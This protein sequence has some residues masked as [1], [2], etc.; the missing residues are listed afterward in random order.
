MDR[1]LGMGNALVDVLVRMQNDSLLDRMEL[2]KGSMQLIDEAKF[3]QIQ[4]CFKEMKTHKTTGGSA[5]NTM[6]GLATMGVPTGFIGKVGNDEYGT[7][8]R[9]HFSKNKIEDKMLVNP[10]LPSGIAS[11]FISPDGERT[12]GT[13]LG[14]AATL[15][16]EDLSLEMFK[17]YTYFYIEGYLVQD[18]DLILRAIELAKEAGLQVCLDMASYN[19]V[20]EE[21]DFFSLLINK[22]VDILFANEEEAKAF[23]GKEPEEALEIFAKMCSIAI[24][25]IGAE[26]SLIRKGS[27]TIR[28]S[29]I[30]IKKV[31]DTTSAGDYFSAGFLYGLTAGY[32]LERCAKIGSILSGNVIQVVGTHMAK[33]R[34]NEIKLN[35][36]SMLAE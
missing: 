21:L 10:L 25:K 30:P 27:E 3:K 12:F 14:A 15:R 5:G 32:S 22:Y 31:L 35:I 20:I 33:P 11:A 1:I 6:L 4:E 8:F 17:G 23:T 7:F 18:H 24:V 29:A 34:W 9:K 2:P 16:A 28:V 36:D 26:G 13:Y 19:I